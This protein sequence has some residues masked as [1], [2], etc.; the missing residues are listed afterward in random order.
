MRIVFF[1]LEEKRELTD[2]AHE[3]MYGEELLKR[4]YLQ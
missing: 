3:F 1:S 2:F 4:F